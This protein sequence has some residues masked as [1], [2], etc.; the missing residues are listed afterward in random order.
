MKNSTLPKGSTT[1]C[2]LSTSLGLV[3]G[4][5]SPY[6]AK[7]TSE[8][9]TLHI[10]HEQASWI[11]SLMPLGRLFGAIGGSIAVEYLGSKMSLLLTGVPLII[12][13]ICI[14]F[15][16][17][18]TWLYVSRIFSGKSQLFAPESIHYGQFK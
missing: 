7:L 17:S 13:W 1:V 5:T 18:A 2:L 16:N 11:A 12:G 8:N 10:T 9:A 6:L 4:W 14:I 15:A 3:A